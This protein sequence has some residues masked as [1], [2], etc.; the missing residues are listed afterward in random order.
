MSGLGQLLKK[1][2]FPVHDEEFG[3][4]EYNVETAMSELQLSY[5]DLLASLAN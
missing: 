2:S 5:Y 4:L 3:L 1:I